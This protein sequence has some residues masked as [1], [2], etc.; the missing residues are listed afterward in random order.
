MRLF[1]MNELLFLHKRNEFFLRKIFFQQQIHGENVNVKP[2][3][4]GNEK[5]FLR[6]ARSF[7][8]L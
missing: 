3:M 6:E 2:H 4:F 8:L 1:F 5:D 7:L